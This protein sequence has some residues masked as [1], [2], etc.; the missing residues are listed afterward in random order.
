MQNKFNTVENLILNFLQNDAD[1]SAQVKYFHQKLKPDPAKYNRDQLPALAVHAHSYQNDGFQKNITALVEIV[2]QGGD[3]ATVDDKVKEIASLVIDK[4]NAQS[5][6]SGYGAT[7]G[8]DDVDDI[9]VTTASVNPEPITSGF[10]GLGHIN[11]QV[12]I[13]ER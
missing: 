2:N 12:T 13:T 11:V 5:A 4:L 1:V 3:M 8:S 7:L 10:L 9:Q 6:R